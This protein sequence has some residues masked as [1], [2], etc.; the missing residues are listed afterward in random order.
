MIKVL[1]IGF[2]S[3]DYNLINKFDLQYLKYLDFLFKESTEANY[4]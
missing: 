2:D 1:I 3:L 4:S